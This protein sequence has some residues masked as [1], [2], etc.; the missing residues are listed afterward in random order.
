MHSVMKQDRLKDL[1][2]LGCEEDMTN[3]IDLE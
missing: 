1:L 2:I 3:S